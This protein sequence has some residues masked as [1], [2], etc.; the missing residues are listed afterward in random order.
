MPG[1]TVFRISALAALAALLLCAS[2]TLAAAPQAARPLPDKPA[3]TVDRSSAV[4]VEHEGSDT[5]GAKLAFQLK[6]LFNSSSLFKLTETDAPKI[7]V[8]LSTTPEFP[9]RPG[10]ASAYAVVWVFSP[11]ENLLSFTLAREV[12]VVG[13]DDLDALAARLAER[14]DGV[15]VKY[16]YLFK[17]D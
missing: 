12:G 8:L 10:L 2:P 13:A 16:G 5:L 4:A 15:A 9:S 7:K 14:S 6:E 11:S 3:A 17:K 1:R